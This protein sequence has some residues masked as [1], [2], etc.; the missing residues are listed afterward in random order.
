MSM[1]DYGIGDKVS[2]SKGIG[3]VI[4]IEF[5]KVTVKLD[6]SGKIVTLSSFEV[7]SLDN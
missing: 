6:K 2:T 7:F 5:D 1:F 3:V 4:S